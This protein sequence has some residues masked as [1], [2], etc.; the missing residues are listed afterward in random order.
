MPIPEF[1][2]EDSTAE[3]VRRIQLPFNQYGFDKYGISQKYLAEFY[4]FLSWFY[5]D[6]FRVECT[7]TEHIPT[8][9]RAMLVGNH[10]GGIPADAGMVIAAS[11]FELEPPRL[12]QG[13]VDKFAN[14]W[15]LVSKWFSRVGQFT[16]LPEH[17]EQLLRNERLLLVFP[18]GSR[19]TGKLFKDRYEL[20]RFGTG[21]MRLA[22]ETDTPIIPF[23]FVGG[24]EA[25]PTVMHLEKLASLVGA[26]YIP[27]TPYL[28]P[29]PLP[30]RCQIHFGEPMRF[31]GD[32]TEADDT[33]HEYVGQVKNRISTLLDYGRAKRDHL[34]LEGDELD[35]SDLDT[36]GDR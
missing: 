13:M 3:R 8:E 27:I 15:P 16:G 29:L 33:I 22:L 7:G 12:A 9:G 19:G 4:T 36:G 10:S 1:L 28:L 2:I 25:V 21:F 23:G 20:V 6:Y 31:S 32:G 5:H 26:P 35:E 30:V 14:R 18:E 24:E 17:A 34:F 11:F